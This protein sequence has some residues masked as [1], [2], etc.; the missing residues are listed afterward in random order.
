MRAACRGRR[1]VEIDV[2]GF[3]FLIMKGAILFRN[4]L[5]V[6]AVNCEMQEN[7]KDSI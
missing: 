3:T 5:K 6:S 7:L 4:S 1:G 2:T